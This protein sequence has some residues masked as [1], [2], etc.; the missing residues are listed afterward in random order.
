MPDKKVNMKL[1][2]MRLENAI[3][4]MELRI[5]KDEV[6]LLELDEQKEKIEE[7][8]KATQGEIFRLKEKLSEAT[9]T[10][11]EK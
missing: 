4:D 1:H 10:S 5:R 8:I 9:E 11:K 3:S 6:K 2:V 7:N